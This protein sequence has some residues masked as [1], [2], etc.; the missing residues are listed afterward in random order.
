MAIHRLN[1]MYCTS[2]VHKVEK[3]TSNKLGCFVDGFVEDFH[4]SHIG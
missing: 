1:S 2:K 4:M 3:L